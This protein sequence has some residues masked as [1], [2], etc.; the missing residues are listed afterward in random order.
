MP[1]DTATKIAALK[2]KKEQLAK[3]LNALE[4]KARLDGRKRETRQK[5]I[6]GGLV[7]AY[8]EKDAAFANRIREL[9][10]G[11]VTRPH[12]IEAVAEII[13]DPTSASPVPTPADSPKLATAFVMVE[14]S[15][16]APQS[17]ASVDFS[18]MA[19]TVGK[20]S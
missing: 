16:A 7:L 9:I 10:K 1:K 11:G 5:I 13:G 8:M 18:K 6:V 17:G 20:A 4:Q 3:R 2:S 12:D 14:D 15:P 19:G